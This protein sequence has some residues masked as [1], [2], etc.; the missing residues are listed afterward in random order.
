MS[1][2]AKQKTVSLIFLPPPQKL[3]WAGL[4]VT[5]ILLCTAS[6]NTTEPPPD[7]AVLSLTLE[8]VSCTEA[9]ITLTTSNLQ[10][11]ATLNLLKDNNITKTINLQTA[12]TLLYIDS[13]LP[14][15][16]YQC[17]VSSDQYQVSSN[18]L[19]VAT[20]DTTSHNFTF[21]TWTFGEH[22][23]SVL[24]DVAIVGDEIWAVGAIY[25][26]D[27][28]GNL[29]NNPY[30]AVHWDGQKW[31]LKRIKTNACGGVDYPP[32]Q[33]IFA[34]SFNDVLFAHIDG[35]ISRYNGIEF[36][37]DCSL[38]TQLNGSANK[39]WGKSKNDFYIVS[40]NGFIARYLNGTWSRI[41]SGTDVNLR[42]ISGQ[43]N[44][45]FIS[46]YAIDYS[47]SVLLRLSN[48]NIEAIWENN[49][50]SGT[51]PYGSLIYSSKVLNN[52]L[53][54]A[55]TNGVYQEK[56]R[57][58][59]PIKRL[60]YSFNAIY[61]LTGTNVNNIFTAGDRSTVWHY[62][63]ITS[64]QVYSEPDNLAPFY[65]ADATENIIA[66]VGT[67][68]ENVIYHKATILIGKR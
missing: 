44:E 63:G 11:P 68:V 46:G 12:D 24:F 21:E 47:K 27:S 22:G 23:N 50:L 20:M 55:S 26:K 4:L 67:R 62:N 64:S 48:N 41:E 30:N 38:I 37:N 36:T 19:S 16:T 49:S 29:D 33:A 40:G 59:H 57:I 60:F 8:D 45:I 35:G 34:F 39:M 65:S 66:A 31:E 51:P 61:K 28:L 7:K 18:E 25:M 14:N 53:F 32:I 9:W 54:I 56:L 42:D 52:N 58:K 5:L 43:D 10:L 3:R 6:C 2:E 1:G 15:Q 17:Q 13:L